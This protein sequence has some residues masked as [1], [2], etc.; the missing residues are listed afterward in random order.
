MDLNTR[1]AEAQ[2]WKNDR[3]NMFG[4]YWWRDVEKFISSIDDYTPSTDLN[5][6]V[7]FA[8]WAK[9]LWVQMNIEQPTPSTKIYEVICY[10]D[11]DMT[12]KVRVTADSLAEALCLATLKYLHK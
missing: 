4:I 1:V 8:E 11:P 6:A 7:A 12:D 9:L 10:N 5:Q 3:K 2:G